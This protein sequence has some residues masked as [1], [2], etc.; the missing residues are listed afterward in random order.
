VWKDVEWNRLNGLLTRS[1]RFSFLNGST[2]LD[3]AIDFFL[4]DDPQ[5]G[6]GPANEQSDAEPQAEPSFELAVPGA[7]DQADPTILTESRTSAVS[8]R[9]I[10]PWQVVFADRNSKGVRSTPAR[11]TLDEVHR[12]YKK[13]NKEDGRNA[14][15]RLNKAMLLYKDK[16][17]EKFPD[18]G[19]PLFLVLCSE[20][21]L[22]GSA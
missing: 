22:K 13:M 12:L 20:G 16:I 9:E 4:K 14:K 18:R 5:E 6:R 21:V 2:D 11:D 19:E 1:Y 8:V 3:D 17:T 10:Q 7:G 15:A